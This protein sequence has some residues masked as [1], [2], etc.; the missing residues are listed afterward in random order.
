MKISPATYRNVLEFYS[1][2]VEFLKSEKFDENKV[3]EMINLRRKIVKQANV[4]DFSLGEAEVL[5]EAAR[6]IGRK[7]A[8]LRV[9]DVIFEDLVIPYHRDPRVQAIWKYFYEF[10]PECLDEAELLIHIKK[11]KSIACAVGITTII[12]SNSFLFRELIRGSLPER[13]KV[14]QI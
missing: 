14:S 12:S 5:H 1:L 9:R 4:I 2:L 11:E 6:Q 13:I 10:S 3:G 8:L 7:E